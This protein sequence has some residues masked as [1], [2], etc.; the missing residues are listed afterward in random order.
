LSMPVE[1]ALRRLERQR[2]VFDL[3]FLDPPYGLKLVER[4]LRMIADASIL[5]T[6]GTVVAEHGVHD[7]VATRYGRL[8]LHS[9]RRYGDTAL[10]F[11]SWRPEENQEA[12]TPINGTR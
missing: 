12:R 8:E 9:R 10:S 4:T 3:I 7:E 5:R 11:F 2:E 6:A 1:R